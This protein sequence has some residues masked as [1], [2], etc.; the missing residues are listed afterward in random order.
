MNEKHPPVAEIIATQTLSGDE[1]KFLRS[2]AQ[3]FVGF[4]IA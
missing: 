3:K 4:T 1:G 2:S